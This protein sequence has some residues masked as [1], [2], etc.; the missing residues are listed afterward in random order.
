MLGGRTVVQA[1]LYMCHT[2]DCLETIELSLSA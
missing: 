1:D 2:G